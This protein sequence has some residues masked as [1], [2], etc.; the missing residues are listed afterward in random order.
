MALATPFIGTGRGRWSSVPSQSSPFA[1]VPQPQTV[2]P[3]LTASAETSPMESCFTP[4]SPSTFVGT[5]AQGVC[6]PQSPLASWPFLPEPHSQTV[7]SA[8]TAPETN[9]P[10]AICLTLCRPAIASGAHSGE[11]RGLVDRRPVLRAVSEGRGARHPQR[12]SPGLHGAV[13][14]HEDVDRVVAGDDREPPG[15]LGMHRAANGEADQRQSTCE[16]LHLS[17]FLL[18]DVPTRR[19]RGDTPGGARRRARGMEW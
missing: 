18:C 13:D 19:R 15:W 5:V 9:L 17:A 10:A 16:V 7:P 14:F 8:S 11:E 1:F 6:Q 2:P 3:S 4:I 12:I